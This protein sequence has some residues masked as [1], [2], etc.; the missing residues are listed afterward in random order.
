[1]PV[2]HA[3][4]VL[5]GERLALTRALTQIENNT[6][7]GLEILEALFPHTG[8]A[9]L[10]GVTGAP[11]TGK[12]TLVNQLALAY[13]QPADGTIPPRV[14]IV[15]VDPT[16]PFTGGAILG[17]RVRMQDLTGDPGIFIRSMAS[18]GSLGGLA[19]ATAGLVQVFDA[20]GFEIII[21]ETVGAGQAE[22]D[23][24]RLAHSTIVVEAPGLGD[25]IQTIKAGILEIADILV[26]NKS[27]KPGAENTL[28]ALRNMLSM[29]HPEGKHINHHGQLMEIDSE[30]DQTG[31]GW[32]PAV[33]PTVATS[34]EGIPDLVSS[35]NAHID[36][37]KSSDL[38]QLREEKRLKNQLETLLGT[39]LRSRWEKSISPDI[40]QAALAKVIKRELSPWRAVE[41]LIQGAGL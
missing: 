5:N 27:D 33:L 31:N 39:A 35:L 21:I 4:A 26:V 20:A 1:M 15:A 2:N 34:G 16:S 3:Q 8:K 19:A 25:E 38:W 12:S 28:R 10:I 32:I 18:R 37:L 40:Y 30:T 11:G 17:D 41:E 9:H 7:E 22:V 36:F 29:A 24:A 13:R 14:A 23:I 6:A